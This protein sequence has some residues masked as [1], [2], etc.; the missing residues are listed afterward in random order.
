MVHYKSIMIEGFQSFGNRTH[1]AIDRKGINFIRG[2]NGSGKST[3]FNALLWVEYGGNM[4]KSIA[5]WN[6]SR[7][8]D[9][10]G[11]RVAVDRTDGK[12]DYRIVRHL[13]YTGTTLGMKGGS[14]LMIFKKEI[15]KPKFDENDLVGDALH[16]K[17]MQE[18]II[19]QIG[20]DK[21]TFMKSVLF[22][23]RM[24]SLVEASNTEKRAIFDEL[25]Y[26]DFVDG[27]KDK[28]KDRKQ[29]LEVSINGMEKFISSS[30]VSIESYKTE[31]SKNK[32]VLE[33]FESNHNDRVAVAED[34]YKKAKDIFELLPG[35][36]N[37]IKTKLD[38]YSED[39]LKECQDELTEVE[40]K[41]VKF[42]KQSREADKSV[43]EVQREVDKSNKNISNFT[44]DLQEV[45][46]NCPYCKQ[47]LPTDKIQ[48]VVREINKKLKKEKSVLKTMST[49]LYEAQE[50]K[51]RSDSK[52]ENI[53][54]LR[55]D[56]E[57][58]IKEIKDGL[59]D[60]YDLK[61]E[62]KVLTSKKNRLE[63]EVDTYSGRLDK[64]KDE[65]K[66]D[67]DLNYYLEQISSIEEQ[68]SKSV[69]KLYAGNKEL[70][71]VSWWFK[72]GFGSGGLKSF[73]FKAMLSQLNTSM[74]KY[75]D[76][77]GFRVEFSIDMDKKSKP[78]TTK[79]FKQGSVKDYEDLSGGQKQRVDICVAFA[80]H[81]LITYKTDINLLVMDEFFEGIDRE[82]IESSFE[83][84]KSKADG[85]SLYVITHSDVTDS[86]NCK[87]IDVEL[88]EQEN[89]F[90]V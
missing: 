83:I 22:G 49:D 55:D 89:S 42:K 50:V 76:K 38:K 84:L 61:S 10:K 19:K 17:N 15:S 4:K 44:K 18:L 58:K 47:D 3:I 73:V 12:H 30:G 90:L 66:P 53:I 85:R 45:D 72:T 62:L 1:I 6:E 41:L 48:N 88:D 13:D 7:G 68:V 2:V 39:E 20:V 81:D 40:D 51:K 33:E 21:D 63:I 26:L 28:A 14:K 9:W 35:S 80:M 27:A 78:F 56:F 67:I 70:E 52:Y 34:D 54:S 86:I 5:T 29:E 24:K 59:S 8:E 36:I 77:L 75:A 65:N 87:T 23:Q 37:K 31:H 16:K 64:V 60:Y 74:Q 43:D 46:E 57:I 82:G 25:F 79:V 69:K 32:K 11:T 71:M